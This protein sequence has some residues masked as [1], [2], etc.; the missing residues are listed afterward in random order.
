[1]I[2]GTKRTKGGGELEVLSGER[3]WYFKEGGQ[4]GMALL[5]E[6]YEQKSRRSEG[7][8]PCGSLKEECNCRDPGRKVF[9]CS[10]NHSQVRISWSR[11]KCSMVGIEVGERKAGNVL[12][13]SGFQWGGII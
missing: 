4:G 2:S 5:R 7:G 6:T 1:M 11:V 8:E 9:V 10:G 12:L 3:G 13:F